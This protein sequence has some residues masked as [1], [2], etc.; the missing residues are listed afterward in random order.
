VPKAWLRP[1]HRGDAD[2]HAHA[3]A[4]FERA[5]E[6][7]GMQV[8]D[9]GQ[10]EQAARIHDARRSAGLLAEAVAIHRHLDGRET[11]AHQ[12]RAADDHR[13]HRVLLRPCVQIG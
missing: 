1:A 9:A 3:G 12:G 10:D 8:D 2:R 6:G 13:A 7:V 4:R 5:L 11:A